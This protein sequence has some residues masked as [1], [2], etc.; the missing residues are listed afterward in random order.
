V[1]L[2]G[3]AL[4]ISMAAL[5]HSFSNDVALYTRSLN[6]IQQL[7]N[8][9]TQLV[10]CNRFH[11]VQ[12]RLCRWLMMT[13]DWAESDHFPIT[14]EFL[15]LMLGVNRSTVSLEMGALKSTGLISYRQRLLEIR[16]KRQIATMSCECYWTHKRDMDAYNKALQISGA[17][18]AP[19]ARMGSSRSTGASRQMTINASAFE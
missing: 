9:S 5:K 13:A 10:L 8:Q 2:P 1:Q 7:H 19:N 4:K 15:S 17:T 18:G 14:H 6:L 3:H 16:N 11:T 12:Q